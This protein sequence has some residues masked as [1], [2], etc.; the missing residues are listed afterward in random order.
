MK[1]YKLD[2]AVIAMTELEKTES[3]NLPPRARSVLNQSLWLRAY[4]YAKKNRYDLA[5]E[6]MKRVT[7]A[8]NL[9]EDA[10]EKLDEYKQE[11]RFHPECSKNLPRPEIGPAAAVKSSLPDQEEASQ[12]KAVRPPEKT[13]APKSDG[14]PDARQPG[15]SR[16]ADLTFERA[17]RG[18]SQPAV[19]ERSQRSETVTE[20]SPRVE[21]SNVKQAKKNQAPGDNAEVKDGKIDSGAH[22]AAGALHDS[23]SKRYSN[24]LIK[25][26][27]EAHD[28]EPPS[29]EEWQSS[30]KKDF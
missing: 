30:G 17:T 4:A 9:F 18:S 20:R 23:D 11:I 21:R 14:T 3:G 7:P 5:I 12:A 29:F 1:L 22:G 24:L 6:D 13:K 27:S 15:G 2:D 19:V 8:F 26:F 25:Y 28:S 16:P 10:T